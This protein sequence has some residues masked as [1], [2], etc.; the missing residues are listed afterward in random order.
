N[1]PATP[2]YARVDRAA[3]MQAIEILVDN[4]VKYARS[5]T[6][7]LVSLRI[8]AGDALIR[9]QDTGVG[10]APEHLPLL[11]E[12]FYRVD[13]ARGTHG[14]GLGLPIAKQILVQH[15]GSI[16]VTS[17]VGEGTTWIIR[18]PVSRRNR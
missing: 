13:P 16:D 7:I 10:I 5:S 8:D 15:G 6:P 12:R 3:L 18:L 9:V 14:S 4:A 17:D 11:F 2:A 1:L